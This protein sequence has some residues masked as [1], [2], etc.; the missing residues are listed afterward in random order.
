MTT[1]ALL[2]V[3]P[4]G[5]G[6]R[7]ALVAPSGIIRNREQIARA[8]RNARSLGWVPVLGENVEA[9]HAYFAGTDE[10][11]LDDL[12]TALRDD[13][14]DAI[15]C[16]RGGYGAMRLLVD[17][18]FGALREN[19]RAVIGFSDIT[20][21]HAAIH[22][23]CGIVTYHGPTARGELSEISR[24]HLARAVADP[25]DSCGAA[26]EGRTLR[27]GNAFGRLAGGNLALVTALIGTP[28]EIDLNGAI[29]V[30]EDID[31]AVY[32]VDRMMQQLLLSGEL[33]GCAGIVAGDFRRPDGEKEEDNRTIDDV[34]AEAADAAGVPCFAG[35]PFGHIRDQWTIPLGALAEMRAGDCTLNV[36]GGK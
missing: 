29:L 2:P 3:R 6:A 4:P 20:A 23:E 14:I 31:E 12:N 24:D 36:T 13:S 28:W 11:R 25:T 15:W 19:P 32:R 9:G 16:V 8:E 33:A 5:E 1:N 10:E 26:P 35:A 18:D 22:R 17:I 27:T 30:L 21:L 34:I 7:V